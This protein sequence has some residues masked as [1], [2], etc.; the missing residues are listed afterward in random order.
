MSNVNG[1]EQI[2]IENLYVVNLHVIQN[3]TLTTYL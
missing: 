2:I 3:N 1:N